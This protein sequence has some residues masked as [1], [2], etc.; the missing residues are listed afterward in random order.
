MVCSSLME[1]RLGR[2]RS[3][4]ERALK[5]GED[6][7][8]G[9]EGRSCS[10]SLGRRRVRHRR[11]EGRAPV[12]QPRS[13]VLAFGPRPNAAPVPLLL[14]RLP[15]RSS[16]GFAAAPS[17]AEFPMKTAISPETFSKH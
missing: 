9:K 6:A 17:T 5:S 4:A 8:R 14:G 16:I 13:G 15:G 1:S 3:S 11:L 12:V 10:P 2:H 7:E